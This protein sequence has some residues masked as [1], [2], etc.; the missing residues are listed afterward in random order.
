ME[1]RVTFPSDG[2]KLSGILHTP[3]GVWVCS[4]NGI[5][6]DAWQPQLSKIPGVR[7]HTERRRREVAPEAEPVEDVHDGLELGGQ[8]PC[9][10]LFV[11]PGLVVVGAEVTEPDDGVG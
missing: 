6:A 1:A 5:A 3:D 10:A 2:L 9:S 8:V 4:R 11:E 7:T